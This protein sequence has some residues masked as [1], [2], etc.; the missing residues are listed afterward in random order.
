MWGANQKVIFIMMRCPTKSRKNQLLFT[1]GMI[2]F[3]S[4]LSDFCNN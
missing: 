4:Y 2:Y 3:L 1:A